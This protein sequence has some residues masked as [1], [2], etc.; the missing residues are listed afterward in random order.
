MDES[1]IYN[2][3]QS[4]YNTKLIIEKFNY[5]SLR[6]GLIM[7]DGQNVIETDFR[8][9]VNFVTAPTQ[10]TAGVDKAIANLKKFQERCAKNKYTELD[11]ALKEFHPI[12]KKYYNDQGLLNKFISVLKENKWY[13]GTKPP[14]EETKPKPK[15]ETKPKPR[16]KEEPKPRPKEEP[17]PKPKEEKTGKGGVGKKVLITIIILLFLAGGGWF[18]MNEFGTSEA[19]ITET[20]NNQT[21]VE[22]KEEAK[23]TEPKKKENTAKPKPQEPAVKETVAV[24]EEQKQETVQDKP[25]IKEEPKPAP[26]PEPVSTPTPV[27]TGPR[28]TTIK[29]PTG[30]VYEGYVDANNKRDG[31]GKYT[32]KSGNVY[33]GDWKNDK[34]AGSGTYKSAEGW[35]Y[36]GEFRNDVFHGTGKYYDKKGKLLQEG[37]WENGKYQGKV[38][39]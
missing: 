33:D 35:T 5:G 24:S 11:A 26:D 10:N 4:W 38:K 32:Y 30:N 14:K 39:K 25:E 23:K 9:L 28:F 15:E 8:F 3:A 37:T 6:E 36:I 34:M 16:P 2:H 21:D 29:Y 13:P 31:K 27:P 12:C 7:V 20:N 19:V 1:V 22:Q 17:K 18:A